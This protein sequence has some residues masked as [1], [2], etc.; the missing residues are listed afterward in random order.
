M[1][2]HRICIDMR[3]AN[4]AIEREKHPISIIEEVLHDLNGSTVFRKLDL[5]WGFHQ[6]ELY[7]AELRQITSFITHIVTRG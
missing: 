7:A 2:G 1:E 6:V 5:K 4:E 3:G